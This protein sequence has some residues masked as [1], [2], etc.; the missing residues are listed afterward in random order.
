[1]SMKSRVLAAV[2]GVGLTLAVAV[3]AVTAGGPLSGLAAPAASPSAA[4]VA[5]SA[6]MTTIAATGPGAAFAFGGVG[7]FGGMAALPD[8]ATFDM[9]ALAVGMGD[10]AKCQDVQSKLAANLGVT[11]DALEAAI[12]KTILQ[13]IDQA[14][15]DGKLTADQAKTARDRVNNAT[16]LCAGFGIGMVGPGGKGG[17]HP[18]TTQGGGMAFGMFDGAAYEAVAKY[19]GISTDQL[20]Q[21][22]TDLGSLQ[23]IAAKYGK[24][25][26]AGKAGLKSTIEQAIKDQLT[27]NGVPQEM[28]DRIVSEFTT[29]FDSLYTAKLGGGMPGGGGRVMPGGGQTGPGRR[30]P[31]TSPSPSPT[32]STQ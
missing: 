16:D 24:D 18:A 11:T 5:S 6:P 3:T 13:E 30:M 10:P 15:K 25:N 28:I 21:D 29:N 23:A 1:M 7:G 17:D 26:D 9:N 14:E 20:K 32:S 27:K 8:G 4:P 2:G 19:F 31:H 22:A 12:K